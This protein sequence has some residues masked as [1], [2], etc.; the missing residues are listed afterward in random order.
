M[1]LKFD[2]QLHG[3]HSLLHTNSLYSKVVSHNTLPSFRREEEMWDNQKGVSSYLEAPLCNVY[4]HW[5]FLLQM[6]QLPATELL[7]E[8]HISKYYF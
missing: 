3:S 8:R 4:F 1:H 6:I 7:I 5:I 2:F